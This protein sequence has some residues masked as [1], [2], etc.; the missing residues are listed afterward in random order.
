MKEFFTWLLVPVVYTIGCVLLG[1]AALIV[2]SIQTMV[3]RYI[4]ELSIVFVISF[5]P[6][7]IIA[8][9]I[10]KHMEIKRKRVVQ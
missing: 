10:H 2:F 6:I 1:I 4:N 7:V 3:M 5:I 8:S 9:Q